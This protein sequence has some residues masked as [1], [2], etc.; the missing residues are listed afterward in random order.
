MGE[1]TDTLGVLNLELR[2]NDRAILCVVKRLH[3][4]ISLHLTLYE[5]LK[6]LEALGAASLLAVRVVPYSFLEL[7]H[8]FRDLL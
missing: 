2:Q 1:V 8:N 6:L 7:V 5:V 3:F 4:E